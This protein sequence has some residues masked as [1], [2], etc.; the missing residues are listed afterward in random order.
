MRGLMMDEPL[1]I[2]SLLSYAAAHFGDVEIVSAT[3]DDPAH[4]ITY[5]GL[6]ARTRKLANALERK[7]GVR[8]GERL[9]T[10]AWNDYRHLELYYGVAGVGAVIHTI[11]PR[12]FPEQIAYIVNHAQD[13]FL[14]IDPL[15]VPLIEKL[16]PGLPKVERVFVLAPQANLP[17][18]DILELASYETLIEDQ[19]ATYDWP[20]LD[21]R[22]AAALCYTSGTT[23]NPKGALYTQRSTVL[24]ALS[25]ALPNCMA[26]RPGDAI[27]PVVP[28][29]H[30]N[31]WGLPHVAP[32]IGAKLVMP[33]PK[34]DGASLHEQFERE[35]VTFTAG[36]PTIWFGLLAYLR[37]SGKRLTTLRSMA[38]GGSAVPES[39]IAAFED[40]YGVEVTQ[41][42]GMTEM[43]PVGTFGTVSPAVARLHGRRLRRKMKV[44]QGFA[45]WGVDLKIVDEEGNAGWRMTA[46][47]PAT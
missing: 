31:A 29:F 36:V 46:G 39:M 42:W 37:E 19:P 15:F 11:N 12:L 2:S 7:L 24:H 35:Q 28:M 33:G 8:P 25:C 30:V 45:L 34:L 26:L 10:L 20:R 14:F 47:P 4:R 6:D 17:A 40:E 44:K 41:G 22:T 3:A 23:G 13:R 1:A 32:L 16:A 5:A 38:I 21:E 18:S 43:S 27:L 9:A